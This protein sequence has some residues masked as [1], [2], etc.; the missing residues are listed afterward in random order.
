MPLFIQRPGL[1]QFFF[2]LMATFF[3]NI[4]IIQ[5]AQ[6]LTISGVRFGSHP[7]SQRVVIE[8]SETPDFRT[9]VMN[10]PNRVIVDMPAF[11]WNVKSMQKPSSM[12]IKDVRY[13]EL[14][15]GLSR[16]VIETSHPVTIQAAF[17]LP[18]QGNQPD[19]LVIDFK[20]TTDA[21]MTA[22]LSQV[23]GPLQGAPDAATPAPLQPEKPVPPRKQAEAKSF[24]PLI[25][26]DPGHGGQDPGARGANG[27]YEKNIVLA[28]AHELKKQLENSGQ[29]HVRMTR[30]KDVFIAL[31][32]L[33]KFARKNG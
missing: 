15:G 16:I 22:S 13:G 32:D 23:H 9:F 27:A 20:R 30:D 17:M 1:R 7:D 28:V 19:R 33:V 4:F 3:L 29:Y 8:L 11:G 6:A 5:N 21:L 2:F 12:A 25:V 18:R 14:G 24:K 26:I 10:A 31:L